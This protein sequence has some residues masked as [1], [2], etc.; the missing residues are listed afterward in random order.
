MMLQLY[1]Y[2]IKGVAGYKLSDQFFNMETSKTCYNKLAFLSDLIVHFFE[3][4]QNTEIA[5]NSQLF[6]KNPEYILFDQLN[7]FSK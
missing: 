7:L 1:S 4:A 2:E 3:S 5:P 6:N